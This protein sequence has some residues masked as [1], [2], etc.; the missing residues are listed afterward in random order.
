M[1]V[2]KAFFEQK[3]RQEDGR[4][5]AAYS[6]M[7][8]LFLTLAKGGLAIFSGSAAILAETIHSLTDVI[9]SLAV[10]TGIVI[11]RKKSPAFPWGLYKVENLVALVSAFF[12]FLMAYEVGKS[13][14]LSEAKGI[15]NINIT[16]VVLFLIILPVFLFVWYEKKKAE[17]LNSPSLLADAK[18]WI[19][20]IASMGVVIVGLA[21]SKLY[22]H[23]DKIA[24]GIVILFIL[25]AGYDI[26][27]DSMKSLLDASVDIK[28][29]DKIREVINSFKE[30]EEIASLNARNSGSFIFVLLNLRVSVKKLKEAH[31]IADSIE[32]AIRKDISFVERVTIHYEPV[33]KD[34]MRYAVPLENREGK[35][36]EHFGRAPFIALCDKKLSNGVVVSQDI[37][38]NPFVKIEKGKGVKL[39]EFLVDQ[40][41]DILYVKEHFEG[42]GPEYV[43]SN[44]EVE[45]RMI[46]LNN[47]E[48]LIDLKK[49]T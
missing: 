19:T 3:E 39:A 31:Q 7:L 46:E 37:V 18:H 24:A 27:K 43:F 21:C 36:S 49:E 6:T 14:L 40:G 26:V 20:H 48:D 16:I 25:K 42:K 12:I 47:L 9:G 13:M 29:L 28:T 5:V 1:N 32:K 30:V 34:Y 17:E 23:A 38:D 10:W 44:A 41:I 45:V 8:N 15:A 35:I 2:K 22:P 33:K 11:S 4:K